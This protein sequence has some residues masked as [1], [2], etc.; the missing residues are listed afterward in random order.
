MLFCFVLG[1]S[2]GV[3]SESLQDVALTVTAWIRFNRRLLSD[4][5]IRGQNLW[6]NS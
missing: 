5:L 4:P 6:T 3:E 2:I 1:G